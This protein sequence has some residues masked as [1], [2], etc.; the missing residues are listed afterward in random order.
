MLRQA[1]D[2][3]DGKDKKSAPLKK[4]FWTDVHVVE[5]D[6]KLKLPIP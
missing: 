5:V 3:R 4:R 1:K 6:G 2:I